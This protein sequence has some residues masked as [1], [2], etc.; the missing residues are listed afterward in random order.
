MQFRLLESQYLIADV[1]IM[2]TR[3]ADTM[4]R[5]SSG[6][7]DTREVVPCLHS[8]VQPE[9]RLVMK[10]QLQLHEQRLADGERDDQPEGTA[11][12]GFHRTVALVE[13]LK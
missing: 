10:G 9:S 2:V 8:K 6:K 12:D 5:L 4:I 7:S 13:G 11:Q 1:D 3:S